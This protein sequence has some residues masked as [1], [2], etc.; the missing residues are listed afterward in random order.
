M[1]K[2]QGRLLS[3]C[4]REPEG[5]RESVKNLA[6]VG[7]PALDAAEGQFWKLCSVPGGFIF[8]YFGADLRVSSSFRQR[9][10]FSCW[11]V[12]SYRCTRRAKA[13]VTRTFP[14]AGTLDSR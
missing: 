4:K 13:W 11:P 1:A 12:A 6:G 8:F 10:A 2:P 3:M 14:S 7:N 5:L 9:S